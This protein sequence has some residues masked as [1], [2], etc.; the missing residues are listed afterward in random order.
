MGVFLWKKNELQVTMKVGLTGGIGSGKSTALQF[1]KELGA[2]VFCADIEAKNI[3]VKDKIVVE[4]ICKLLGNESYIE[5]EL[6]KPFIANKIFNNSSLLLSMNQIVH[7]KVAEQ[8][9]I[10]AKNNSGKLIVY[11]SALIVENNQQNK[12]DKVILVIAPLEDRITRVQNRDNIAP[13]KIK[14]RIQHQMSDKNK[15]PLVDYVVVNDELSNFKKQISK[16]YNELTS[17]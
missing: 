17:V 7:P 15:I 5:G 16:I 6:N 9:E 1:F 13:D 10:F 14:E 12:F 2:A 4:A 11:E 3:M 8:F